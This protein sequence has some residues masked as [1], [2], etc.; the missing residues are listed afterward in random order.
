MQTTVGAL[1]V[2]GGSASL[3]DNDYVRKAYLGVS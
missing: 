3:S 1:V 2:V